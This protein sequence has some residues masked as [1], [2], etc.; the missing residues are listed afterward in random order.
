MFI[1]PFLVCPGGLTLSSARL[2]LAGKTPPPDSDPFS[3]VEFG[4]NLAYPSREFDRKRES[5]IRVAGNPSAFHPHAQRNAC[6]RRDARLRSRL[7]ARWNPQ[8]IHRGASSTSPT[9]ATAKSALTIIVRSNQDRSTQTFGPA[10]MKT[11][12]QR[13]QKAVHLTKRAGRLLRASMKFVQRGW[14]ESDRDKHSTTSPHVYEIRPRADKRDVDL[15]SDAL[16]YSPLWYRGPNAIRD[17]IAHAKFY[18]RLHRAVIRVYD[19]AGNVIETHKHAGDFNE[20]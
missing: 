1:L 10:L 15:T 20:P 2:N 17:A 9:Q 8:R 5:S 4:K 7:F 6:R 19:D 12:A 13:R 14:A 16:P 11:L 18:S 3:D